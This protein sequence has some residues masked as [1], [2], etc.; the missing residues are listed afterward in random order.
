MKNFMDKWQGLGQGEE[1]FS[2]SGLLVL[3]GGVLQLGMG[4]NLVETG[5]EFRLA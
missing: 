5:W 3:G 2:V 1:Y 4:Q